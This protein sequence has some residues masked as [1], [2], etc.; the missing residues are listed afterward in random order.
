MTE[1]VH[2]VRGLAIDQRET[3]VDGVHGMT[4]AVG[5][6]QSIE[7]LIGGD[8]DRRYLLDDLP[9]VLEDRDVSVLL[10]L[11]WLD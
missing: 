2:A 8:P 10:H 7:D 11:L 4:V 3:E 5:G 1:T 9:V 6:V